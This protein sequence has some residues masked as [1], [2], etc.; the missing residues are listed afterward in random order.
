MRIASMIARYLLGVGFVIFGLNGFL[1]FI[2]QPP[3]A[4]GPMVDW[5]TVMTK[6]NYMMPVFAF[7]LLGGL[8]LLVNRYVPLAL[9]ILGPIL[10]NIL[11]FHVL[12]QPAGLPPAIVFVI[13]WFLVFYS[14]RS[15]FA[16]IFE[17]CVTA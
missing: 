9:V 13:L 11:V 2:P 17:S 3:M 15:A 5:M 7:E 6:T 4:P 14:V 16:G 12:L 8:L 10:V 1:H